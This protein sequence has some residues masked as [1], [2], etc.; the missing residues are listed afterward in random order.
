MLVM[1]GMVSRRRYCRHTLPHR[2]NERQRASHVTE[3]EAQRARARHHRKSNSSMCSSVQNTKMTEVVTR[4][5]DA[6]DANTKV[7]HETNRVLGKVTSLSP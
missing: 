2:V 4:N 1:L 6:F 5:T 7:M 3:L